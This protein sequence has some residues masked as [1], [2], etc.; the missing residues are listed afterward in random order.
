MCSNEAFGRD[1]YGTVEEIQNVKMADVYAAWKNMLSSAV[2]YIGVT[3]SMGKTTT[4][5]FIYAAISPFAKT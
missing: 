2:V 4:K 5:E 1:K 3:G